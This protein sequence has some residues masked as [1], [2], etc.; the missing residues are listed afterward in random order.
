MR[1]TDLRTIIVELPLARPTLN[2][3]G[4]GHDRIRCVLVFLDTDVGVTGES[5]LFTNGGRRIEV[6]D[7]MVQSLKPAV[8]GADVRGLT[9]HEAQRIMAAAGPDEIVVSDLTR[10]LAGASGLRFEDRGTH[11]LKGLD[12]EWRLAAYISEPEQ[13]ARGVTSSLAAGVEEGRR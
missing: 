12:G 1:V 6:L 11:T 9:V 13:T 10:T 5:F 2:S 8:V 3:S 7:A 4:I